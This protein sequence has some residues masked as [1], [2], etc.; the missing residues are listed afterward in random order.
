MNDVQLIGAG[1]HASVLRDIYQLYGIK[2]VEKSDNKVLAFG[3]LNPE[4]LEERYHQAPDDIFPCVIHPSA[5]Y[6]NE[7]RIEEGVQ[8]L[9][10]SV[11]NSGAKIG[12]FCII[13]T[14]AIIEHGVTIGKGCHIAPG[15]IV[16]GDATIGD[17]CFVGAGAIVVQSCTVP[18]RTFIKAGSVWNK[19]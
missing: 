3:A 7:C 18:D 8:L 6:S 12:K 17:F 1:G 9:A 16:L 11:V 10:N 2:I 5:T 4:K 19:Q 15:A 14:G 13:N